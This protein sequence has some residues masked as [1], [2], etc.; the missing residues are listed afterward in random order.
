MEWQPSAL[1][2]Q[3]PRM[4]DVQDRPSVRHQRWQQR[5]AA[6]S[7]KVCLIRKVQIKNFCY[8]RVQ[9]NELVCCRGAPNTGNTPIQLD[10]R[11]PDAVPIECRVWLVLVCTLLLLILLASSVR[12]P[13]RRR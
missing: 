3:H 8:F 10:T 12:I 5:E 4:L 2:T 9:P 6:N 1:S 7:A 11:L 13:S